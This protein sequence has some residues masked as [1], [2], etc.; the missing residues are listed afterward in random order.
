[1]E[2]AGAFL[3]LYREEGWY[4]ERTSHYLERVGLNHAKNK[5]LED[6]AGR[7]DLY[8]RLIDS[9]KDAQDPW[10]TSRQEQPVKQFIPIMVEA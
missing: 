7:K 1:M 5:V 10:E 3:Q 4:L 9:L 8:A 6:D 2:Y